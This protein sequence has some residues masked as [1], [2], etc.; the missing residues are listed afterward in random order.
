[1]KK[2]S[3][4]TVEYIKIVKEAPEKRKGYAFFA[5]TIVAAILLGV[6]AIRPTIM[7]I[8][9]INKEIREKIWDYDL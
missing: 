9:K 6:F 7:T 4:N 3:I 5:F 2:E 1:M 8:T